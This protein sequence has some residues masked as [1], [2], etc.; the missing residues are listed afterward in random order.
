MMH[1]SLFD[2]EAGDFQ[3]GTEIRASVLDVDIGGPA[4]GVKDPTGGLRIGVCKRKNTDGAVA[5][6]VTVRALEL[7]LPLRSTT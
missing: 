1:F 4:G 6:N 2:F 3:D 7:G 5:L